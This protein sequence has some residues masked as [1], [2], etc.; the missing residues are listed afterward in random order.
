MSR[1]SID[2]VTDLIKEMLIF[3]PKNRPTIASVLR[4]WPVKQPV[5]S[6]SMLSDEIPPKSFQKGSKSTVVA[7]RTSLAT[8]YSAAEKEPSPDVEISQEL[9]KYSREV[10]K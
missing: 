9:T 8:A 5:P 1:C 4:R 10:R 3:K 2:R 7:R 6:L